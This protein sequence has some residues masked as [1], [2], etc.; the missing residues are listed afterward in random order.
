MP[1]KFT[2]HAIK[3]QKGFVT[4]PANIRF[5]SKVDPCRTDGCWLWIASVTPDGYGQ[6]YFNGRARLAHHFLVGKASD[7]LEY[8]HLCRVRNCV[9]PDHLEEVTGQINSLRG[10]GQG[11][12]NARK[13]ACPKGHPYDLLNTRIEM[14]AH[15]TRRCF[16]CR[17]EQ[18]LQ[19]KH[20]Y[21]AAL[22]AAGL[23]IR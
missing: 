8:D 21:R 16:I 10:L 4:R 5:W 6:F 19:A 17:Q 15:R 7:G 3:G 20:R 13:A 23:P 12:L 18:S 11:A 22:R 1:P 9:N 2:P 14:S